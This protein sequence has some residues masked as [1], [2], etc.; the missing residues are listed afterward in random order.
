M[1]DQTLK[2]QVNLQQNLQLA[3]YSAGTMV[4]GGRL[5]SYHTAIE[6]NA[7]LVIGEQLVALQ[8]QLPDPK[9]KLLGSDYQ[10][11]YLAG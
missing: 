4:F 3:A 8:V 5:Q 7:T 11:Q 6:L 10:L 1:S 2:G 9:G